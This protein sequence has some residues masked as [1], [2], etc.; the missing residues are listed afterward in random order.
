MSRQI[1]IGFF[2]GDRLK[3]NDVQL[4]Y[5]NNMQHKVVQTCSYMLYIVF[6]GS[7][8]ILVVYES[9]QHEVE[10]MRNSVRERKTQRFLDYF[11]SRLLY[12]SYHN[13]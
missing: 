1:E 3:V 8:L 9:M 6:R 13:I 7:N 10:I 12:V 2:S 4:A 5:T 11:E